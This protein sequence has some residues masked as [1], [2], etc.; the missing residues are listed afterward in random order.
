MPYGVAMMISQSEDDGDQ[1]QL[2]SRLYN[3][4]RSGFSKVEK[5]EDVMPNCIY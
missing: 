4:K 2:Y 5:L 1:Q 3:Q